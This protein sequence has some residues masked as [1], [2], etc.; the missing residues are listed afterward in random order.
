VKSDGRCS[1]HRVV[2]RGRTLKFEIALQ[3]RAFRYDLITGD[4]G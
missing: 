3:I 2:S 1:P 4:R